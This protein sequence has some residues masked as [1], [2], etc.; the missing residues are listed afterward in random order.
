MT[1][2]WDDVPEG[3]KWTRA[4]EQR[5]G[6]TETGLRDIGRCKAAVN[7]NVSG[8]WWRRCDA[9]VRK[10]SALCGAHGAQ[11]GVDGA[12]TPAQNLLSRAIQSVRRALYVPEPLRRFRAMSDVEI[13][14]WRYVGTKQAA[15]IREMRDTW[16]DEQLSEAMGWPRTVRSDPA[17]QVAAFFAA[18]PDVFSVIGG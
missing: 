9:P 11:A 10:E 18:R 3:Y 13:L 1:M 5:T 6:R 8:D 4:H 15:L 12:R 16:T 7:V 17:E 2:L 14:R